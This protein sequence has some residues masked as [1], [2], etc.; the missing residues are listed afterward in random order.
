[1][2][3]LKYAR[4][5]FIESFSSGVARH[6]VSDR[7]WPWTGFPLGRL[8]PSW[9]DLKNYFSVKLFLMLAHP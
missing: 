6:G 5:K 3:S 8:K 1:L 7:R 2:K 9:I 4:K